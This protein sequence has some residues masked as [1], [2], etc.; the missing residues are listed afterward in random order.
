MSTTRARAQRLVRMIAAHPLVSPR[1]QDERNV[2]CFYLNT[3]IIGVPF[4]GITSFIA[5]FLAR[6]GASSALMGWLTSAPA[7]LAAIVYLPG[8]AIA[9]RFSDQVGVRVTCARLVRL[10]FLACALLPFVVPEEASGTLA[11]LLV[12]LWT[13]RA[14]FDA[15]AIPAWSSVLARAIPPEGRARVNS[16]RWALLA[17]V[18]AV[19]SAFFGWLLD[20]VAF[21]LNYQIVFAIS[22]AVGWLDPMVFRRIVVP[23]IEVAPRSPRADGLMATLHGIPARLAEYLRP[24]AYERRF[25]LFVA[26]TT[27]YRVALAMPSPLFSLF[28]VNELYASDGLIGLRGTV[29][30]AALVVGYM[31]WGRLANRIGHRQVLLLAAGGLAFYPAVTALSQSAAWIPPAAAIWG[32]TVAG[33]DVGLFDLML[34][35]CPDHRN[36]RFV[37]VSNMV[38]NLAMFIGP[39][40]GVA[41]SDATSLAT[42]LLVIA[43]L[44][45]VTMAPFLFLP[46]HD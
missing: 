13:V 19:S 7:L 16:T 18:S 40:L 2:R 37:A 29:G 12:V 25:L 32:L 28:W 10:S 42:A 34:L 15:V 30:N 39:L 45:I 27:V 38:A 22:F 8:A 11:V 17:I 35:A 4:G 3:A 31:I 20:Q 14:V 33:L 26:A 5:V 21:P 36:Q 9:E 1:N 24:I 6:L 23:L 46:R 41:L 44:Q 43:A